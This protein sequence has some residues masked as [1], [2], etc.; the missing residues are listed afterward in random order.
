[1]SRRDEIVETFF[2]NLKKGPKAF[3]PETVFLSKVAEKGE[4]PCNEC[5][6]KFSGE[7][8]PQIACLPYYKYFQYRW[9]R[10]QRGMLGK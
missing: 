10:L 7:D 1:M 8:C 6:R 9:R 4:N 2:H 3:S 5:P